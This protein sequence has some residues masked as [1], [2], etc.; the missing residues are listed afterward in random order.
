MGLDLTMKTPLWWD[1]GKAGGL[2]VLWAGGSRPRWCRWW[3]SWAP[4]VAQCCPSAGPRSALRWCTAC[5]PCRP[6]WAGGTGRSPSQFRAAPSL[7][8]A[9]K[10]KSVVKS[11]PVRNLG[12]RH[13]QHVVELEMTLF[14][15]LHLSSFGPN[16]GCI[17]R[18]PTLNVGVCG[19]VEQSP[20]DGG[21]RCL[22]PS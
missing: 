10:K 6:S 3:T 20:A 4:P 1:E 21:R 2:H 12:H 5:S 22:S 17:I 14:S 13:I 11:C 19:H 8:N 16:E 18:G 9:K 7:W 15:E